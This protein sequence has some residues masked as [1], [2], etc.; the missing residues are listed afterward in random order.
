MFLS[1]SAPKNNANK[2]QRDAGDM[3]I[4]VNGDKILEDH[5]LR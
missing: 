3:M 4:I 2:A 1:A 5:G